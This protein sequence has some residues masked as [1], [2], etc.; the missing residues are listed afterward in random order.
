MISSHHTF[1]PGGD[2]FIVTVIL[3]HLLQDNQ[4]V[5]YEKGHHF[6]LQ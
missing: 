4:M 3:T 5:I 6:S 1:L 2:S